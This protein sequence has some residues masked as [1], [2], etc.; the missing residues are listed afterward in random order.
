MILKAAEAYPDLILAQNLTRIFL[1]QILYYEKDHYFRSA[2]IR[3][4]NIHHHF[5]AILY[6]TRHFQRWFIH[7]QTSIA[8]RDQFRSRNFQ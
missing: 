7:H 4:Y 2:F 6:D 3:F 1:I 8:W 5:H